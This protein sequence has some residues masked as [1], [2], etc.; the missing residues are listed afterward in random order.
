[1]IYAIVLDPA[2]FGK[3]C[4]SAYLFMK[5]SHFKQHGLQCPGFMYTSCFC[6]CGLHLIDGLLIQPNAKQAFCFQTAASIV[7]L[8][9]LFTAIRM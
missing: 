2:A 8:G 4:S 9:T 1:M 7:V 5:M 3:I 6:M